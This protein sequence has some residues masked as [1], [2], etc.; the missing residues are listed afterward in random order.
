MAINSI[1]RLSAHFNGS[2][3]FCTHAYNEISLTVSLRKREE[4]IHS[5][6]RQRSSSRKKNPINTISRTSKR[7]NH[8][9]AMC[10]QA[11]I[12]RRCTAQRTLS[13]FRRIDN[14]CKWCDVMTDFVFFYLYKRMLSDPF[15]IKELVLHDQKIITFLKRCWSLCSIAIKRRRRPVLI[16][17]VI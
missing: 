15:T 10:N 1:K 16:H 3:H 8:H 11:N 4:L 13:S 6:L 5:T 12:Y 7:Y 17:N 2:M 9:K 14:K